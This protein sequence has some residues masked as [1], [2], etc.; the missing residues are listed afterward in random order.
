MENN[1]ESVFL[2]VFEE[3]PGGCYRSHAIM[4]LSYQT[5]AIEIVVEF[6]EV[7]FVSLFDFVRERYHRRWGRA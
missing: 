1:A 7:I 3:F 6:A 5:R 4:P 2:R